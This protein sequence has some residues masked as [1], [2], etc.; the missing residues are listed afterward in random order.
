MI[1]RWQELD[2]SRLAGT[3][4]LRAARLDQMQGPAPNSQ[5][6]GQDK[7]LHAAHALPALLAVVPCEHKRCKETQNE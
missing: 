7:E 3:H 5:K 1:H 6:D 2:L 4:L